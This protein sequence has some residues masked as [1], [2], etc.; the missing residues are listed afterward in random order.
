M[1]TD[2]KQAYESFTKYL[3]KLQEAVN[4]DDPQTQLVAL[5]QMIDSLKDAKEITQKSCGGLLH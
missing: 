5:N 2:V 1:K 4:N 3:A